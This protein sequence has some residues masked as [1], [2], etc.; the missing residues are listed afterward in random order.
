MLRTTPLILLL[1]FLPSTLSALT[2]I[3]SSLATDTAVP[4]VEILTPPSGGTVPISVT[5]T[6][7]TTTMVFVT[8]SIRWWP[9]DPTTTSGDR[10]G[11]LQIDGTDV[12]PLQIADS[13]PNNLIQFSTVITTTKYLSAGPH[14]VKVRFGGCC[15]IYGHPFLV[16]NGSRIDVV[17]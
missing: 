17:Y 9:Q 16:G 5:F 11:F 3:S 10:V 4:Q 8:A 14:T 13:A 2:T 7:S 12:E 15:N 1:S 6:L